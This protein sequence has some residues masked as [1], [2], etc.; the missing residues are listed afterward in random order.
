MPINTEHPSLAKYTEKWKRSRDTFAGDDDIKAAGEAYLPKLSGQTDD[1]YKAYKL[2]GLFFN[3]VDR[4]IEG[5]VGAVMRIDPI[6]ENMPDDWRDD[7][8]NTGVNLND[9]ISGVLV[10][11]LLT[12][13]QGILVDRSEDRPYL[14]GYKA[15]TITNWLSDGTIVLRESYSDVDETDRYKTSIK[16]QYR[17]ITKSEHGHVVHVIWRKVSDK[18]DW[19]ISKTIPITKRGQSVDSD[20]FIPITL[21]GA[22]FTPEKPPLLNL[23]DVN[24]SHYRTTADLEHGRHYTALPTPVVSGDITPGTQLKIGAATAWVLPT[25]STATYLEFTG[26]GLKALEVALD[27]KRSMM[28]SLGAQLLDGRKNQAEAHETVRIRANSET[29]VLTRAVQTTENAINSALVKMAE[30]DGVTAPTVKLN[31]DFVDAKLDATM[32]GQLMNAFLGGGMTLET[33]LWNFK[34][35]EVLGPETDIETEVAKIALNSGTP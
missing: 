11:Q 22:N 17:E 13:R 3:A 8:T 31:R 30:W 29:S 25:G 33:L 6:T 9:F 15:E 12:A 14:T 1:D 2:R 23:V 16:T 21:D 10:E 4:T 7:I 32:I 28:A 26:Q 20:M 34:R 18:G 19:A 24:L 27:D 35:G 5:L